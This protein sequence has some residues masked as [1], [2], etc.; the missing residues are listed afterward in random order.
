ML[1]PRHRAVLAEL[2]RTDFKLRYQNSILGYLWTLLRPLFMFA[3]LYVVFTSVFR[4]GD[5]VPHYG[6]YLL[7]G[8]V[9]WSFF[10]EVTTRSAT[11]F[12]DR[13]DMIRK[14]QIPRHLLVVAISIG[15]TINLLLNLIVIAII[16]TFDNV[17]I[18]AHIVLLPIIIVELYVLSIGVGL[19]LS[20]LYVRLRDVSYI[21][22]ILMQG[23]FYATPIIYPVTLLTNTDH[24][25]LLLLNP[26]AQII[27]DA[28]Y[29]TITSE[30]VRL[31]DV[32]NLPLT[33]FPPLAVI[34]IFVLGLTYYK[35]REK[36][37]AEQI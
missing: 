12:V 3:I 14:I 35:R 2:V 9:L 13:G 33:L 5:R 27:Q 24:Q 26:I 28:R 36:Y 15:A 32:A 18:N 4:V 29:L 21:W 6:V 31:Y 1:N 11:V 10:I 17:E 19:F 22:E 16:S 23:G 25:V 7:F 34:T 30:T 37:F 20:A 8:I